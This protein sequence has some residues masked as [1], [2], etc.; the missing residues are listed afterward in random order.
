M[1]FL[2]TVA[3]VL[4]SPRSFFKK[5]PKEKG[6]KKAF[7][8]FMAILAI[9]VALTFLVGRFTQPLIQNYLQSMVGAPILA[10]YGFAFEFIATIFGYGLGLGLVFLGAG[11]LHVWLMLWGGKAEYEK[12]FQLYIYSSTPSL[13]FGW[14]PI[15]GALVWFYDLGLLIIGTPYTHKDISQHRAVWV[16][17]IPMILLLLFYLLIIGL[18]FFFISATGLSSIVGQAILS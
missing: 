4:G 7:F 16:Y 12:T 13:L 10:S 14:I 8:F 2:T 5:L 18:V 1:S 6:I 3:E 15:L 9:N 11:I 17:V